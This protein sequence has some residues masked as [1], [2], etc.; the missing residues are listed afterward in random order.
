MEL[1]TDK[2]RLAWTK[3]V[4]EYEEKNR[5]NRRNR[6]NN[7][8]RSRSR[9]RG[10]NNQV[11]STPSLA[12]AVHESQWVDFWSAGLLQLCNCGVVFLMPQ[13]VH[14]M[15]AFADAETK[16]NNTPHY[17]HTIGSNSNINNSNNSKRQ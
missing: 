7:G 13:L 14:G 10:G 5:K 16:P 2:L 6:R 8:S 1:N 9:S 4:S 12:G 11:L 17:A 3:R 15:V